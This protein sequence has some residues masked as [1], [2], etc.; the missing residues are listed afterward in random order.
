MTL[1][2]KRDPPSFPSIADVPS[3]TGV[4]LKVFLR[5]NHKNMPNLMLSQAE[6]ANVIAYILRLKKQKD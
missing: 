5:S 1:P 2:D 4:S 6:S 3:T